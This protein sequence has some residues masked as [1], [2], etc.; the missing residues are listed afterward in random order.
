MTFYW[1]ASEQLLQ[2][3]I[4]GYATVR[5]YHKNLDLRGKKSCYALMP[6]WQ[7]DY[8]YHNQ[9]YRYHVNGQTGKVIGITPVSKAKVISYGISVFATVTAICYMA[10]HMLELL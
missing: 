10:V 2:G 3:S 1:E 8:R 4:S 6:V 7:Y 9:V 5:P